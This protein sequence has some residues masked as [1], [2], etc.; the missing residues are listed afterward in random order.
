MNFKVIGLITVVSLS[1]CGGSGGGAPSGASNTKEVTHN[2]VLTSN[3]SSISSSYNDVSAKYIADGDTTT[4][5]FWAGNISGDNLVIDFGQA[6]KL[7]DISV[8]TN[9]TSYN[10][11]NPAVKVELS[12]DKQAWKLT[13]NP[14]GASDIACPTWI[15]GNGKISC[16]F[17][18]DESARYI[19]VTTN[20]GTVHIHEVEATG[21]VKIS[22]S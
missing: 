3:G 15:V 20:A 13:M 21:T 5:N 16:K 18:S 12:M 9:N 1:A 2:V 19:R 6:A 14:Y 7:S 17:S 8:Y 11:S 4:S 22:S 10:S